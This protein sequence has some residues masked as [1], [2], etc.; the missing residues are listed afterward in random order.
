MQRE[1]YIMTD[2]HGAYRPVPRRLPGSW[3]HPAVRSTFTALAE[4]DFRYWIRE[5]NGFDGE[6]SQEALKSIVGK[7]LT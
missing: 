2:E 4:F 1:I 3:S 6:R 7:R 5:G